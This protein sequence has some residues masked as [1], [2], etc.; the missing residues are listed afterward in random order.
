MMLFK[1]SHVCGVLLSRWRARRTTTQLR[2][3]RD[4]AKS[5][6]PA[7]WSAETRKLLLEDA[8]EAEREL[9][10]GVAAAAAVEVRI[11]R[12]SERTSACDRTEANVVERKPAAPADRAGSSREA[13]AH[14]AASSRAA[15]SR[16]I[17]RSSARENKHA[18]ASARATTAGS[19]SRSARSRRANLDAPRAEG[20]HPTSSHAR[21]V[22]VLSFRL[23]NHRHLFVLMNHRWSRRRWTPLAARRRRTRAAGCATR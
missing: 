20:T 2:I 23:M 11:E 16:T 12:T 17:E 21:R 7:M 1:K 18:R 4:L 6:S 19:R 14:G 15:L 22:C 10:E 5:P 3:L 8:E 13:L 9:E